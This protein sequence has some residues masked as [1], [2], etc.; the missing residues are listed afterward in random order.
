MRQFNHREFKKEIESQFGSISNLKSY[1]KNEAEDTGWD[2]RLSEVVIDGV[3]V[4]YTDNPN[5]FATFF[6]QLHHVG[7]TGTYALDRSSYTRA[8]K[9]RGAGNLK[10][11]FN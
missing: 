3:Q 7:M 11:I 4:K 5:H 9:R 6:I 10:P 2:C 8:G 1:L